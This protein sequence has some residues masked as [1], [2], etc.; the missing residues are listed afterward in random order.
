LEKVGIFRGFKILQDTHHPDYQNQ[1]TWECRRRVGS[2]V[3]FFLV[4]LFFGVVGKVGDED[5]ESEEKAE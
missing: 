4:L 3:A 1:R 2:S 5:M